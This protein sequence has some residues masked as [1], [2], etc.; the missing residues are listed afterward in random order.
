[1]G[2]VSALDGR[3]WRLKVWNMVGVCG[4]RGESGGQDLGEMCGV[5]ASGKPF[6]R[7]S[8]SERFIHKSLQPMM[9]WF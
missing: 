2:T 6:D 9:L 7:S 3:G 4:R 1:M 5:V 8:P